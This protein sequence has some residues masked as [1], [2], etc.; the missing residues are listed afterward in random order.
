MLINA[1]TVI[2]G[3]R[4]VLVPY[5]PEHV[6]L[7]HEWM[8]SPELQELTASEPLSLEEEYAMQRAWR[9]DGDKLTFVLLDPSRAPAPEQASWPPGGRAGAM[10]GDGE[11]WL[12]D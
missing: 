4:V 11:G 1:D 5:R 8:A 6:P 3:E 12:A 10:A 9:D 7:Y 2:S